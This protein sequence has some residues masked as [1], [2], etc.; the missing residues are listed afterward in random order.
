MY[1]HNIGQ[2]SVN[3]ITASTYL[4]VALLLGT[5]RRLLSWFTGVCGCCC[6][7]HTGSD[8]PSLGTELE[9]LLAKFS[10]LQKQ[11]NKQT[12]GI[13]IRMMIQIALKFNLLTS[14]QS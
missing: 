14:T 5:C 6:C 7:C 9:W 12:N 3:N 1:I 8:E 4:S 13:M 2:K 11:T 10:L